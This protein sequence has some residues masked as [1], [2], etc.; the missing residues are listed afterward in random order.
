MVDLSIASGRDASL[1]ITQSTA[2]DLR[3]LTQNSGLTITPAPPP[4]IPGAV[5]VGVTSGGGVAPGN[6]GSGTA[7]TTSSSA[8][9]SV[10]QDNGEALYLLSHFA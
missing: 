10:A 5:S 9:S 2:R 1:T 6:N 8:S 7:F 3:A 4:V